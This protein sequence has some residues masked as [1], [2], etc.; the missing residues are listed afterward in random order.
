MAQPI[1]PEIARADQRM[2]QQRQQRDRRGLRRDHFGQQQQHPASGSLRQRHPGAVIGEN[3]PA[4]QVRHHA[5]RQLAIGGDQRGAALW[6]FERFTQQDC[7]GLR[8]FA[9]M[10]TGHQPHTGQAPRRSGQ[11]DPARA[12]G[13]RQEQVGDRA[14]ALRQRSAQPGTVPRIDLGAGHAHP[15]QQQLEV[16]LRVRCRILRPERCFVRAGRDPG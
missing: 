3:F 1:R 11:I 2:H 6:H 9:G 7:D 15:V 4:P 14:A 16:I 8:F 5:A 13:G 12:G 10:R